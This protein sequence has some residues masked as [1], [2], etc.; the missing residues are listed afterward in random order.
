M[1]LLHAGIDLQ[2][3]LEMRNRFPRFS[4]PQVSKAKSIVAKGKARIALQGRLEMRNGFID[5]SLRE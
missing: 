1:G 4:I 5:F 3:R 2:R